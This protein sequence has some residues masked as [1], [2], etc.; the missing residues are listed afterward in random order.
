MYPLSLPSFRAK[1]WINAS[2]NKPLEDTPVH[3]EWQRLESVSINLD[4]HTDMHM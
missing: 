1:M 4:V 3:S 2:V